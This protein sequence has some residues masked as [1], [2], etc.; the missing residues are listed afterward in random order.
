MCL[1]S[2]CCASIGVALAVGNRPRQS[3]SN[4]GDGPVG[5]VPNGSEQWKTVEG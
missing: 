5:K 4:P 2:L 1:F 3:M